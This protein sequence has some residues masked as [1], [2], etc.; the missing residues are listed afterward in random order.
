MPTTLLAPRSFRPSD[1][2]FRVPSLVSISVKHMFSNRFKFIQFN[3]Y[4][5]MYHFVMKRK[6]FT[7]GLSECKV[8]R[9]TKNGLIVHPITCLCCALPWVCCL[10]L[11]AKPTERVKSEH[12]VSSL[13]WQLRSMCSSSVVLASTTSMPTR[14]E[15]ANNTMP[16]NNKSRFGH[17]KTIIG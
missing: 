9:A 13:T 16:W 3:G 6:T 15:T 8:C 5:S 4:T 17:K 12:L 10:W 7:L 11:N 2:Y 14:C 1:G